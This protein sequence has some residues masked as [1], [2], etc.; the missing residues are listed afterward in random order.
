[1]LQQKTKHVIPAES[2]IQ[3]QWLAEFTALDARLRGHDKAG[4]TL[5]I[6][7]KIIHSA[8]PQNA[9]MIDK[10]RSPKMSCLRRQA[11]M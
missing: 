11:S 1:M 8:K 10:E 3:K 5:S 9:G 7:A 6:L 4:P 2:G